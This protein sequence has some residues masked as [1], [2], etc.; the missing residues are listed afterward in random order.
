MRWRGKFIVEVRGEGEVLREDVPISPLG[1][2]DPVEGVIRN[3]QCRCYGYSVSGRVLV[4]PHGCGSTVGSYVIYEMRRRGTAP[5]A[6]VV[7]ELD[8]VLVVGCVLAE[9]GLVQVEDSGFWEIVRT[10]HRLK[11]SPESSEVILVT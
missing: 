5:L 3:P 7:R 8:P 10:G 4:T 11:F 6:F 2:L 9:V 1:D